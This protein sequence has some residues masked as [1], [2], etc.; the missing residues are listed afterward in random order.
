MGVTISFRLAQETQFVKPMLDNAEF[1]AKYLRKEAKKLNIP[2]EIKRHSDTCLCIDIGGCET[3]VFDFNSLWHYWKKAENEGWNYQK[4][5][6]ENWKQF[7]TEGEHYEKYPEQ[8]LLWASDFC[9]TQ[10][11]DNIAEHQFVADLIKTLANRCKITE[12]NDEG[13]YYHTGQI[14]DATKNIEENGKLINS[15]G[16][17][18]QKS[19]WN[20]S[21][22]IKGGETKIKAER[23]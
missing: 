16:G 2:F 18:L 17:M 7:D 11:A 13:D 19:G 23:K 6:L 10:F 21:E 4:A 9:K 5:T 8:K 15:I 1:V 3:L 20:D 12:I 14:N 22:I